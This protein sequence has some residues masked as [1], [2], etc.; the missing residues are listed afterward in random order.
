MIGISPA[1]YISKNSSHFSIDNI[2]ESLS[3]LNINNF[4]SLQLEI[5]HYEQMK[6]WHFS[7]LTEL[8]RALDKNNMNVSQFVAHFLM[9]AFIDIE[10]LNSESGLNELKFL[11]GIIRHFGFT[12]IL[13]I[14]LPPFKGDITDS[15]ILWL[16]DEKLR[17]IESIGKEYNLEVALE[18]Q[19][20]SLGADLTFLNRLTEVGLN[21]DP[22]HINCSGIN[23]FTLPKK[24]LSRVKATHLCENN[25]LKNLSLCPGTFNNNWKSLIAGLRDSGYKG[26][27]DLEIIC[28]PDDVES[29]YIKGHFFLTKNCIQNITYIGDRHE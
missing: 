26:S 18:P 29:E 21:L 27:L 25:G 15:K 14:P 10:A 9:S 20:K 23:P 17:K 7:K 19:P 11:G 3:W 12:N 22:G 1:Y 28:D 13:T 5:F 4:K 2:I 6:Q 8:K 24:I 16:F